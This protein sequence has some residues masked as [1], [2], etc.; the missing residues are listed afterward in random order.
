M[1]LERELTSDSHVHRLVIIADA[2]GWDVRE[3]EDATV[4]HRTDW[5]RVE[6]DVRLFDI[7]AAGLTSGGWTER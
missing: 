2:D 3:E 1:A 4:V 6:S 5:H 7:R